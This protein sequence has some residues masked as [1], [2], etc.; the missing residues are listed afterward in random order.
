M[1][2]YNS[3]ILKISLDGA[4]CYYFNKYE[5]FLCHTFIAQKQQPMNQKYSHC[6]LSSIQPQDKF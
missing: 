3:A 6:S 4:S 2:A 1:P 5:K